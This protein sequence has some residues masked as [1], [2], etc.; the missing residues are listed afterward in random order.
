MSKNQN[1]GIFRVQNEFEREKVLISSAFFQSTMS[2]IQVHLL[3]FSSFLVETREIYQAA[4][5]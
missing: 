5:Q 2:N 3:F 1:Q 4:V